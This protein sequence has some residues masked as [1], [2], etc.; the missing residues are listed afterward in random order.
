M[1]SHHSSRSRSLRS[2]VEPAVAQV[3]EQDDD[4][5]DEGGEFD[6]GYGDDAGVG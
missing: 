1:P 2:R 6:D 4:H 5:G 3:A